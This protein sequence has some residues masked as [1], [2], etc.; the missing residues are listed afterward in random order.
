[1][2]VLDM[3]SPSRSNTLVYECCA[4]YNFYFVPA[5]GELS[6]LG[7]GGG[8]EDAYLLVRHA[9]GYVNPGS[10]EVCPGCGLNTLDQSRGAFSQHRPVIVWLRGGC[11]DRQGSRDAKCSR[12]HVLALSLS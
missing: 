2:I 4:A 9:A 11:E 7:R 3:V 6:R 12:C 8:G 1:M 10:Y 5:L